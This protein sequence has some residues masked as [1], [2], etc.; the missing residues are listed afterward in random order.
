MTWL[1]ALLVLAALAGVGIGLLHAVGLLLGE[2]RQ[3]RQEVGAL[4]GMLDYRLGR[5]A[6]VDK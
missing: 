1:A 6:E 5:Q 3:L 2:V 4:H